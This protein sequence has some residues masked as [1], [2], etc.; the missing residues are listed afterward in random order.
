M[1]IVAR[2]QITEEPVDE[3]RSRF[4]IEP[5]EPGFGY[6]IGNSLR[7]TLLSSIPGA[8]ISSVRIDGVLHEFSTI[9]KVVEDVTDIILNLK[10]LVIRSDADE[11]TAVYL[12][13]K[14][15]GEVTAG[16]IV[17]P[18]GVEILNPELHI[19]TVGKGGSL[20]ME[21]TI[22]RGVGYRMSDKNKNARDPIGVIP[23]DSI[24]SPVRRVSYSVENTRVEQMTD[25]DRLILD[26][27]TDGSITAR[28][29]VASAGGTL[30][31]LVQL[32]GGLAEAPSMQ[33]G[34]AE[35][36]SVPSDYQITVEDLNL[37]VRSYNCLKREG[38]NTVGDLVEKSE[39]DLMDIR[40]FGQ[41]SIDEV[42]AKLEELGLS[43]REE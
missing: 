30:L 14:G 36:E 6:T 20:E 21:M 41:K 13:A 24:F 32:F 29:A 35:D 3:T 26:V 17:P 34:P 11:P 5:L 28:E 31:E 8:A 1:F 10:E 27:E 42:K 18:A 15:P 2:P 38:I 12:K 33:V 25:R 43:L 19:A 16:D 40:N 9:P 39:A 4:M 22:E 23:V 37:S 7:R